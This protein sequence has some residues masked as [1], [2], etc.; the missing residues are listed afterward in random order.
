M[1]INFPLFESVCFYFSLVC[2]TQLAE[3]GIV[4]VFSRVTVN[5]TLS[6]C[7][8]AGWDNTKMHKHL[9][10]HTVIAENALIANTTYMEV[11]NSLITFKQK[12]YR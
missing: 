5:W 7:K 6:I 4:L 8:K 11:E 1:C 10:Y 12:Y 9:I 2:R 3:N